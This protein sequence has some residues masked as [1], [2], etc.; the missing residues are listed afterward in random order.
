ME[1]TDERLD[2]RH[3][4]G[5]LIVGQVAATHNG[6]FKLSNV[7]PQGCEA[8]LIF[9]YIFTCCIHAR[10]PPS[11]WNFYKQQD[12]PIVMMGTAYMHICIKK[13]FS[14]IYA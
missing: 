6:D 3:G 12:T 8:T 7:F 1:S 11:F 5:L 9:P 2:L 10:I 14:C 4:L 13:D